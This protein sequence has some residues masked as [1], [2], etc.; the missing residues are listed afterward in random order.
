MA[1]LLPITVLLLLLCGSTHCQQVK[2]SSLSTCSQC[3]TVPYCF[4]CSSFGS[5]GCFSRDNNHTSCNNAS[6]IVDPEAVVTVNM[7]PLDEDHQVSVSSVQMKLRVGEP[8]SFNLSVKSAKKLSSRPLH[9]HGLVCFFS[10]RSCNSQDH[11]IRDS[12][13]SSKSDFKILSRLWDFC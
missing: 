12:P 7:L 3:L 5:A 2:C 13:C 8:Q 6:H 9:A 4:W 10:A 1:S 11:I